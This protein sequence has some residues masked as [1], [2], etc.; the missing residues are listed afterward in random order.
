VKI[1]R[2]KIAATLRRAADLMDKTN[3]KPSKAIVYAAREVCPNDYSERCAVEDAAFDL[4]A[5]QL[6]NAM[7]RA[8]GRLR[9]PAVPTVRP[10]RQ[11]TREAGK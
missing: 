7:R 11:R 1:K 4:Y 3:E 8:A 6:S 2:R 5:A 10:R 9:I